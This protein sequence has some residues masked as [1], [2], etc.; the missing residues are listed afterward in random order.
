MKPKKI[1]IIRFSSIGDI[2]LTTPVIRLLRQ[3]LG[4]E[5]H[6]LTKP[7]FQSI[8]QANPYISR[9]FPLREKISD[10]IV[11]LRREK[12]DL[13]VDLHKNLRS[14]RVKLALGVKSISFNKLNRQKWLMVNL[15]WNLL[16]AQHIVDR[17]LAPVLPLGVTYD[18][19]GLDYFIPESEKLDVAVLADQF[20][21]HQEK[22]RY[23]LA[24]QRYV[25]LV[26]GA[27]HATKRLLPE[28][29]AEIA[30]Q[31]QA[32]V[33]L[34]GGTEDREA[35]LAIA[36]KAGAHVVNVCGTYSLAGSAS[37]VEQ[38]AV[39]VSHDTGLM[40]IAAA[41]N[42]PIISIWGNTVPAFGMYPFYE[43]G[44]ETGAIMEVKGLPCRP[45]SKIGYAECPKGH[46]KC[47]K[48]QSIPKIVGQVHEKLLN[49]F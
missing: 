23:D 21:S 1:L 48:A 49:A 18:G 31:I 12:Y 11:E 24:N 47:M 9:V 36:A 39:V 14:Q 5:V 37:L 41:F 46:F 3:Q 30:A 22:E 25:A 4:A 8:V 6:Y 26:V 7:A 19:L 32:P 42:R 44:R 45:C 34:L 2:V 16:P 33:L 17:Y 38:A 13:I 10:T 28:Q 15:K 29:L 40:H 43:S 20:F 27:A 35:G